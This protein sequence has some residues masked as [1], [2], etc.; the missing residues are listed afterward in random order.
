MNYKL[1]KT[2]VII[3]YYK[4]QLNLQ[5]NNLQKGKVYRKDV[6]NRGKERE[7]KKTVEVRQNIK[8][9]MKKKKGTTFT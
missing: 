7:K 9:K 8:D 6:K 1:N 3:V 2:F 5:A 4:L